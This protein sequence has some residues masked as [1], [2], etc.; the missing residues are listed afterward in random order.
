MIYQYLHTGTQRDVEELVGPRYGHEKVVG[1]RRVGRASP[2][3][4]DKTQGAIYHLPNHGRIIGRR[5]AAGRRRVERTLLFVPSKL[6]G[7]PVVLIQTPAMWQAFVFLIG[8]TRDL[9]KLAE[10]PSAPAVAAAPPP[11]GVPP[12]PPP[13]DRGSGGYRSPPRTGDRPG[14]LRPPPPMAP[15][16]RAPAA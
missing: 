16:R 10:P 5:M 1:R 13:S 12:D 14:H 15:A 6:R 11:S 3:V 4:P 9:T 2:L 8:P 7:R